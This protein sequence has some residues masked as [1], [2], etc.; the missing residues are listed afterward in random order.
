MAGPKPVSRPRP[1]KKAGYPDWRRRRGPGNEGA[2]VWR[3]LIGP[4][5]RM[6]CCPRGMRRRRREG[7]WRGAG[8]L[9]RRRWHMSVRPLAV[10]VRLPAFG[11]I[12]FVSSSLSRCSTSPSCSDLSGGTASS[13]E[14]AVSVLSGHGDGEGSPAF[15]RLR[16]ARGQSARRGMPVTRL[17]LKVVQADLETLSRCALRATGPGTARR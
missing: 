7:R 9:L 1:T 13:L 6:G 17:Q 16:E 3:L 15:A 10:D 8:S 4:Q 11:V 2:S 12:G 5:D 14:L